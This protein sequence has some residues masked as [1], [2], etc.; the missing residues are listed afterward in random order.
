ML[1]GDIGCWGREL[2][3]AVLSKDFGLE[4]V[5]PTD[6]LV[7]MVPQRLNYIHWLEDL[8]EEKREGVEGGGREGETNDVYGIDIGEG[9]GVRQCLTRSR[10]VATSTLTCRDGSLLYLPSARHRHEQLAV[11]GN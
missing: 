10:G 2:A 8:L 9:R 5:L 3:C 4:V 7:P 11:L 1:I 6:R